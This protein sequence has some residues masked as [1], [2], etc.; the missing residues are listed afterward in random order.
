MAY[1]LEI[2]GTEIAL[3]FDPQK[4]ELIIRDTANPGSMFFLNE[5]G[6]AIL[7]YWLRMVDLGPAHQN[8]KTQALLHQ[9]GLEIPDGICRKCDTPFDDCECLSQ[10]LKSSITE[11]TPDPNVPDVNITA[12]CGHVVGIPHVC[13]RCTYMLCDE[14]SVVHDC[15]TFKPVDPDPDEDVEDDIDDADYWLDS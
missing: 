14:C 5:V 8:R 1:R 3:E 2:E 9:M 4:K 10:M 13:P 12:D 15:K 6:L 7:R 11:R